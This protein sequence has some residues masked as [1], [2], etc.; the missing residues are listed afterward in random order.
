[1]NRT[2]LFRHGLA[3]LCLVALSAGCASEP[4]V[5][6]RTETVEIVREVYAP[7]PPELTE[8]ETLPPLPAGKLTNAS[9]EEREEVTAVALE[10]AN[11]KLEEIERLSSRRVE[12]TA[13]RK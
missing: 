3:G 2:R 5:V 13:A 10:R 6:V 7:I 12:E 9:L 1:M 8:R 11:R 4:R